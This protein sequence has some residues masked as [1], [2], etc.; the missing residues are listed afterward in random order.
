L[1]YYIP[2]IEYTYIE[3]E[4]ALMK[5]YVDLFRALS[6]ETRLRIMVLLSEKELCVCQIEAALDLPQAK[7]SRHLAVLRYAGLV[8]DR[9]E[10]LWIYYSLA[11]P[12]NEV[13]KS[14]FQCF[15]ECLRKEKF[16]RTDLAS[17]KKCI[18]QPLDVI[19]EMVRKS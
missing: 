17:M 6:D 14:L 2:E 7:V 15:R 8:K 16:F 12:R 4:D 13:E 5:Q 3:K 19:A 11:E 1:W 10:G 9:R 18:T